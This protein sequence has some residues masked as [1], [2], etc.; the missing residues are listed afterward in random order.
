M[1]SCLRRRRVCGVDIIGRCRFGRCLSDASI[2]GRRLV[3]IVVVSFVTPPRCMCQCRGGHF[4]LL[5]RRR[6]VPSV[7][8]ALQCT[9]TVEPGEPLH[10][11]VAVWCCGG[12]ALC[13][14][15]G[16]RTC[17]LPAFLP[18]VCMLFCPHLS[19]LHLFV[20]A[21]LYPAHHPSWGVSGSLPTSSAA[22]SPPS[23]PLPL[24]V[25]LVPSGLKSQW[26][27]PIFH[28]PSLLEDPVERVLPARAHGSSRPH[29]TGG[30]E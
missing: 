18:L 19:H 10:S 3:G 21:L 30:C 28:G 22:P 23:F 13:R 2:G 26:R 5:L 27:A 15:G 25:C 7:V 11:Y 16:K 14:R 24:L 9:P 6:V 17:F 4:D 12:E 1:T 8:P 29:P 20:G